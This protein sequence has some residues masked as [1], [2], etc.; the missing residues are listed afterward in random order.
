MFD[1]NDLRFF[2]AL[3]RAGNLSAAARQLRV[4]Q[5]TVGRRLEALEDSAREASSPPPGY[6]P[7]RSLNWGTASPRWWKTPAP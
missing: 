5:T 4:N 2:L 1:W 7:V 3:Q 6:R